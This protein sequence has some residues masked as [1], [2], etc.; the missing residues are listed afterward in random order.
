MGMGPDGVKISKSYQGSFGPL[1]LRTLTVL[2]GPRFLFLA[3]MTYNGMTVA[4][5]NLKT[6]QV[7]ILRAR[8]RF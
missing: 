3:N 6:R 2:K 7:L 1:F 5:E 4:S 8:M